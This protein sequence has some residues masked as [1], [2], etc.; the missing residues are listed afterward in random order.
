MQK[1]DSIFHDS[2]KSVRQH[3][4]TNYKFNCRNYDGFHLF[5]NMKYAIIILTF[6]PEYYI[7]LKVADFVIIIV[8]LQAK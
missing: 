5:S 1:T 6:L 8:K 2:V 7:Y 4:L 3:Q